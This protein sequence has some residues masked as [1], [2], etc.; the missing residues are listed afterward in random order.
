MAGRPGGGGG[1][2]E[3]DRRRVARGGGGGTRGVLKSVAAAPLQLVRGTMA[4]ASGAA[5]PAT[6]PRVR[7][8]PGTD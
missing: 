5:D 1:G 8:P 3:E 6:P 4:L 7:P 2:A